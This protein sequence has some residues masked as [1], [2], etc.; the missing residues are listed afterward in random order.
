MNLQDWSSVLEITLSNE[1]VA[2]TDLPANKTRS[3]RYFRLRYLGVTREPCHNE[4]RGC[5]D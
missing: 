5:S 3:Y 1:G 2:S 4:D